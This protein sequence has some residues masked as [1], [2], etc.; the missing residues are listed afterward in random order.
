L[1]CTPEGSCLKD[2][3]NKNSVESSVN[4]ASGI[5]AVVSLHPI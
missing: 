4:P 3:S 1:C 2:S 5:G